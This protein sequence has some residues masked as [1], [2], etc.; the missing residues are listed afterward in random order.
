VGRSVKSRL[1]EVRIHESFAAQVD[2]AGDPDH[3]VMDVTLLESG[4]SKNGNTYP[5]HVLEASQPLFQGARCFVDHNRNEELPER[6][7]RDLVGYYQNVRM[8]EAGGGKYALRAELHLI[9]GHE[10]LFHLLKEA[11]GNPGLCGLSIDAAGEASGSRGRYTVERI[12]RVDSV[13]VVTKPAAGGKVN[14]I[15]ASDVSNGKGKGREQMAKKAGE[16]TTGADATGQDGQSSS[17]TQ[18]QEGEGAGQKATQSNAQTNN[19]QGDLDLGTVVQ[20]LLAE[21]KSAQEELGRLKEALAP[22]AARE[23]D[24]AA[25]LLRIAEEIKRD[26]AM[27]RCELAL[28]QELRE[29]SLPGPVVAKLRRQF[30]GRV[31]ETQALRES[32]SEEKEVLASLTAAGQVRGMGYE[33]SVDVGMSEYEQL[34]A[35]FDGLFGI[36]ESEESRRVP[37]LQGIREAFRIACGRDIQVVGG[38]DAPLQESFAQGLREKQRRLREQVSVREE[39]VTLREADVTTATFS[40]LLGTSM[41]K[42][43]LAD[44]QAWPSEWQKFRTI[45][46]IKDFKLQS[47]IR[48]GAF[49]SLSTVAE[50]AAYTTLS[51]SDTQATYTATKRG[52]LVQITRETIVNDDLYAIKQIPQKLAV[53]AAFTLAEFVYGL[54]APNG[55]NIYDAH[56]LFDSVNH[57]NT[58]IVAANLGTAN[59]GV[60]LSSGNL[61]TAVIAMRKQKNLA[62]KPIGLKPRYLLVGPDNEFTAMTILKSAGLPGGNNNDINPMM[63]YCEPIVSAQL[64]TIGATSSTI[65]IAVADPKVIDTV[66]VGFV[67][68]QANPV[69]LIQDMPLYGLNFTQDTISYKV[70]HEYGGAVVDYRGFYLGNN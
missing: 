55:A 16:V 1:R 38:I 23:P 48:L 3:H 32:I 6:S 68:G 24:T 8:Q 22:T 28:E 29:A 26:R 9:P 20:Q 65:W 51:V 33:K 61:Q 34:Q 66:E 4:T 58:G 47:R 69:L 67:G 40:Y 44:Y 54:L 49:G 30:A 2:V 12:A 27:A 25:D 56:P 70:R 14:R 57:L 36:Y 18:L 50:D 37:S 45:V 13:D 35:A 7:V 59:S 10:W 46:A 53:A 31:F 17:G 11:Q 52:N 41:N 39:D 19:T 60:A 21:R 42:R 15:L 64:P 5:V 62:A 63:G 43:L